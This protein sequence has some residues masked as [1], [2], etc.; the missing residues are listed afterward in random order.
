MLMLLYFLETLAFQVDRIGNLL[1]ELGF[2]TFGF[3]GRFLL[4][5]SLRRIYQPKLY[6]KIK[7]IWVTSIV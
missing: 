1:R 2:R 3:G 7:Q 6:K 4:F 5:L